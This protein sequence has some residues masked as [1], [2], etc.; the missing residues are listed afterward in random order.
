MLFH[1]LGSDIP[2]VVVNLN[3]PSPI[4][5]S[6]MY[7]PS[8]LGPEPLD[9]GRFILKWDHWSIRSNSWPLHWISMLLFTSKKQPLNKLLHASHRPYQESC[10]RATYSSW[11]LSKSSNKKVLPIQLE[12]WL[13]I[14]R[15]RRVE[16]G[17]SWTCESFNK[18][19]GNSLTY[20]ILTFVGHF[21]KIHL[22]I[23]FTAFTCSFACW[24]ATVA[25]LFSIRYLYKSLNLA[26]SN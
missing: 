4:L 1:A 21:F 22:M 8:N 20:L 23:L 11:Y 7:G 13:L 10:A 15:P 6:N 19:K 3:I 5:C 2:S 25:N 12:S 24:H 18:P 9:K 14:R 16:Y 17:W 26:L